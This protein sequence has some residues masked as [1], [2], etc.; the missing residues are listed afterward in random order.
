MDEDFNN[1]KKPSMFVGT[2]TCNWKCCL[3]GNFPITVCQNQSFNKEPNIQYS[4]EQLTKRYLTN[5]ITQA[6]IFGGLEPMLQFEDVLNFIKYFREF[7]NDDIVIYSGYYKNEI[8]NEVNQLKQ[9]PNII[10]KY[11]RYIPNHKSHY[12][13]ILGVNLASDNQYSEKIS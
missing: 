9:Y 12:D 3:D 10:I 11:G 6:I 7:C 5:P 2:S 4:V 8:E 1:Y 13:S